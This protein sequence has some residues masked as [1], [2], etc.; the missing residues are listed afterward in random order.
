MESL[1]GGSWQCFV[2]GVGFA[3]VLFAPNPVIA[4]V[5]LGTAASYC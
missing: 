1:N 3:V 5:G 2:G 4:A